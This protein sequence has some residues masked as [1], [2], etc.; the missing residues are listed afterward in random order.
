MREN[1][2]KS[3]ED[4]EANKLPSLPH[5]LVKLLQACR[6]EDICFETI[7]SIIS[8]DA[9]LSARVIS[10]ANSPVYGRARH[11]SSLKH[12][13]MFLGLD[14]IKSIAIT[15]AVQQFF[16]RY[17]SK[18]NQF[19][20]QFWRHSL[21]CATIGRSLA[22]LSSYPYPEE[23]YL[24]GLL[25]DIGKL[26]FENLN[27]DYSDLTREID[28]LPE[29]F[30]LERSQYGITHD[31]LGGHLL[32]KW[33]INSIISDAVRYHHAEEDQIRDAHQLVKI[34]QLANR[35]TNITED[36]HASV[37]ECTNNLFDLNEALLEDIISESREEMKQ[38]ALSL[39]IDIGEDQEAQQEQD[40][41]KQ[42]ALAQE[43]RDIALTHSTRLPLHSSESQSLVSTIH[44]CLVILFGIQD[45]AVFLL[46]R[47]TAS[48]C[49]E[50]NPQQ[51]HTGVLR[52]LHISLPSASLLSQALDQ[53]AIQYSWSLD[54]I[55]TLAVVDQQIMHALHADA[56]MTVPISRNQQNHGVIAIGVQLEKHKAYLRHTNLLQIFALEI[57]EAIEETGKLTAFKQEITD[58]KNMQF[59][60]KARE[61]IHE[62]SNPLG[63]IRNY[64]QILAN[65]L[66][67]DDPAQDDISIIKEEID[68]VGSIILRCAEDLDTEETPEVRDQFS[69]N[70]LIQDTVNIFSSSLFMTHKIK[71]QVDLD[72]DAGTIHHDRDTIKQ[73]ITNLIKN[74]V[75]AMGTDG[76]IG[77]RTRAA[78]INGKNFV[79]I[80]IHDDG[81][82]IPDDIM[83]NLYK[84]VMTTKGSDHSGLG[85][86]IVKNLIDSLGGFIGCRTGKH[87]TVFNVQIPKNN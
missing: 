37:V 62:T 53:K 86:S 6:D 79:D 16:S 59:H 18:K 23:A 84:P 74:A 31:N 85:L 14:T 67:Q 12:L 34:V 15:A 64:L 42:I 27:N 10:V 71:S 1:V 52:D 76:N 43:V 26:V 48:L 49:F 30:K 83:N 13:L 58:T 51:P 45:A 33:N 32:E 29:L 21:C 36:S 7:S 72:D 78:N 63:V 73:I 19:L 4:S 35:L 66:N 47:N 57:A 17:S 87:G 11:L 60:H 82:G 69:I 22:K 25:H 77:I 75:E 20:K 2:L 44:Q 3:L 81:P 65:R 56:L 38:V 24:A 40:E 55:N 61:I 8:R 70:Q 46:D 80:E 68:R 54:D 41:H 39:D 28:E 5:I 50:D 9:A